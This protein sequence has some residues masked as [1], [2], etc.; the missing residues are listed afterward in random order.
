M[1]VV[2][3]LISILT[4]SLSHVRDTAHQVVCRSNV[5]QMGLA[6][7]MYAEA[8]NDRVPATITVG[9]VVGD[10]NLPGAQPWDSLYLR[11]PSSAVAQPGRWDGLGVLYESEYLPAPKIFYCPAHTGANH[12][13]EYADEW[14]G[15]SGAILGNYQYRGRAPMSSLAPS[16]LATSPARLT[17][18]LSKMLPNTALVSDGFRFQSDFNHKVGANIFRANLSVSWFNDVNQ[19]VLSLLPKDGEAPSS[20]QYERTWQ[21]LDGGE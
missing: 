11:F 15:R 18:V 7:A 17:D 9:H 21:L 1:A 6:I 13:R 2:A 5:R 20:V 8:N 3:I 14:A 12:F 16:V 10:P 4:P 19:D